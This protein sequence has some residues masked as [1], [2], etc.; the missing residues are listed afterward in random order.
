MKIISHAYDTASNVESARDI[1][2]AINEATNRGT[3]HGTVILD[4]KEGPFHY[5]HEPRR[6]DLRIKHV[7]IRGINGAIIDNCGDGFLF[8]SPRP[9]YFKLIH[10]GFRYDR[11]AYGNFGTVLREAGGNT[12]NHVIIRGNVMYAK[13]GAFLGTKDWVIADNTIIALGPEG[14]KL[15]PNGLQ[16]G[17]MIEASGYHT[18]AGELQIARMLFNHLIFHETT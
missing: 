3:T 14:E 1:V 8:I 13:N 5:K 10:M 18:V 17:H 9:D 7:T 12:P 6:I 4:G 2:D 16:Y 11:T 15:W